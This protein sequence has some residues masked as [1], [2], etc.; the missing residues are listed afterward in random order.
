MCNGKE[1]FMDAVRSTIFGGGLGAGLMFL[2]DPARG[3]RRRA[4]VRDTLTRAGHK[5]K[6]AYDATR[7]DVANRL[8]GIAATVQAR[9]RDEPADDRTI[10]ARVRAALGRAC[11]HPKAIRVA[12]ANGAVTLSGDVLAAESS[13]V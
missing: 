4:L 7:R 9:M 10:E 6:D 8:D 2:F 11:S 5:S 1:G 3:A 13:A 12:A